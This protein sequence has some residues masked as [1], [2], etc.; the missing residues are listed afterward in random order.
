[1]S[2]PTSAV[3]PLRRLAG[4]AVAGVLLTGGAVSAQ[5]ASTATAEVTRHGVGDVRL[6]DTAAELK[7]EGLI[8]R[9]RP[10]CELEGPK[11]RT[12]ALKGDAK[13]FVN[14]TTTMPRRV[15]D[16]QVRSGAAAEGV[17]IGATRKKVRQT[18]PHARFDGST[19]E[20]F[21]ITLVTV[22]KRD[23]GRFQFALRGGK[24]ESIGVPNIAFCE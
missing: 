7:E 18:F 3:S 19:R 11:A 1:M 20:T 8:G 13:G 16:I 15:R 22:P 5:A 17:G 6:G 9:L 14:F 24:V 23:G 21:G 12:A 2:T 4:L 10:G